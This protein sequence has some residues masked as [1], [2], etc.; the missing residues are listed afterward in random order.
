MPSELSSLTLMDAIIALLDIAIVTYAFYRFLVFIRGT[1]AVQLIKGI[2]LLLIAVPIARVFH[3][4]TIYWLLQ[5]AKVMLVVALPI[6]F[7]P[8]LRRALEQVGRGRFFA[9]TLFHLPEEELT[10]FIKEL[11]DA[12]ERLARKRVGA[13]IV[14]ERETRLGEVVETG[15]TLDA[16]ASS[17]LL[18]NVFIPDTPLHDG[19]V[20]VR[21]NRIL[22]AACFLPLTESQGLS[23]EMGGRHRAAL[24]ITEHS[25]ALGIVVSEETGGISLANAGKLI[26]GLDPRTLEELL[27]TLIRGAGDQGPLPFWRTRGRG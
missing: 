22:A 27:L 25:D 14:L 13:L 10:G 12:V 8:E 20:I 15:I 11:V 17:E 19:A 26:R 24:G 6:V 9:R 7:Q 3:L 23:T 4:N 16:A 5:Q 21:G 2:M 1:R 18:V